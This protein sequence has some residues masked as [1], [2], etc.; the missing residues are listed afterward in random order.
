MEDRSFDVDGLRRTLESGL[1]FRLRELRRLDGASALNFKAVRAED[2]F[3]FAVKC[4]PPRRK[5]MFNHLVQHLEVLGGTKAVR[6]IFAETCP[7]A[8]NGYDLICLSWCDGER[9]LPDRLTAEQLDAFL[10][11]YQKFSAAMQKAQGIIPPDTLV[12]W[13][14]GTMEGPEGVWRTRLRRFI[15]REIP[16]AS[17]TYRQ[18]RLRV[19]HGDFHHGNFLF[20][21]GAVCGFLDL[22]EFAYGYPADD[23]V[24]WFVCAAEHLGILSFRRRRRLLAQFARA[25]AA[26]PY[27]REE[28]TLA[29]NGLLV[30]KLFK[31]TEGRRVGPFLYLNLRYRACLYRQMK[32]V[33]NRVARVG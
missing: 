21:D 3:T 2:G 4:S 19:I 16:L 15:E 26:L 5:L 20:K 29:L 31:K 1:G 14:K 12:D 11:D 30:R 23:I 10:A 32:G 25:V 24:R 8:F 13:R 6:R 33:V 9:V 27:P 7:A 22:E 17:V 18:D 28:W